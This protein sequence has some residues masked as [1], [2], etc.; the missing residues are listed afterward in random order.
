MQV[1]FL[2]LQAP[3]GNHCQMR[4][5]LPFPGKAK[6]G[7]IIMNKNGNFRKRTWVCEII[8]ETKVDARVEN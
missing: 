4:R 7:I 3:E 2:E 6:Q 1:K 8:A 5:Q